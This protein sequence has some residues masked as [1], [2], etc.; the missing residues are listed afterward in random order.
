[1]AQAHEGGHGDHVAQRIARSTAMS[2]PAVYRHFPSRDAL[3]AHLAILSYRQLAATM[4]QAVEGGSRG[5]RRAR[6]YGWWFGER[7]G[8]LPSEVTT[9]TPPD[10]AMTLLMDMLVAVQDTA[11]GVVRAAVLTWTRVH[12]VLGLELTGVFDHHTVEAQRLIG[13][14]ID[15]A[16]Q[17]LRPV[18]GQQRRG[19]GSGGT[20]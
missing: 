19:P 10:H 15:S 8:G 17:R 4:S 1:M 5:G 13:L 20:P 2:A 18:A 12:G 14:G 6:G 3:V 16:I 11:P 7:A 9:Q